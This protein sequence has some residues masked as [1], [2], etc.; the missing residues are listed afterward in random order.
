MH[1]SGKNPNQREEE[2]KNVGAMHDN[3]KNRSQRPKHAEGI[4][5]AEGIDEAKEEKYLKTNKTLI[6]ENRWPVLK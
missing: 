2:D 5:M 4:N 3:G 6:K 1:D